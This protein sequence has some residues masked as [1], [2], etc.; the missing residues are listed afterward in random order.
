MGATSTSAPSSAARSANGVGFVDAEGD[1]PVRRRLR[2]VG[3]D[4]EVRRDH[5]LEARRSAHRR[6][7]LAEARSQ[8][9]EMVAVAGERPHVV[10]R[11]E[12]ERLPAEH[13]AV[14]RLGSLEV[15]RVEHVEVHRSVLVDNAGAL[16]LPRLPD[17]EDRALRVC[18]D[19]HPPRLQHVE[20]LRQ[21]LAAGG[22]NPFGGLVGAVDADRCSTPRWEARPGTES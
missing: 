15:A 6:H 8:L 4:P 5:V 13:R 1:A 19:G 20:R 7:V 2:L 22:S 10:A 11:V 17:G 18:E 12:I 21:H 16:V 9:L 3:G 14:E